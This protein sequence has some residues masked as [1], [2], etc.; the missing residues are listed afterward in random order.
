MCGSVELA[1]R[2]RTGESEQVPGDE[3]QRRLPGRLTRDRPQFS[4][5]P[6]L[7]ETVERRQGGLAGDLKLVGKDLGG[8]DKMT[9]KKIERRKDRSV[10]PGSA[11]SGGET[12]TPLLL[13]LLDV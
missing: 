3:E 4:E 13:D 1:Q 8:E 10:A 9:R 6:D 11:V 12:I 2:T 7:H 5:D